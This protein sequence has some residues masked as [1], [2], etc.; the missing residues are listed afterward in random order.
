MKSFPKYVASAGLMAL[1][2][3][4]AV[5]ASAADMPLKALSLRASVAQVYNWTCLNVGVNGGYGLRTE[6]D[7]KDDQWHQATA[8]SFLPNPI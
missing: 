6:S 7:G 4:A 8:P 5:P 2:A 3:G 1:A